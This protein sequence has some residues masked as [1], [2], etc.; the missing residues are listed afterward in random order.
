MR[1]IC[2]F[3]DLM[4]RFRS[5][6][7]VM[8]AGGSI[9]EWQNVRFLYSLVEHF[10]HHKRIYTFHEYL[11]DHKEPLGLPTSTKYRIISMSGDR[12]ARA[13]I[14][15]SLDQDIPLVQVF[16]TVNT[17]SKSRMER[18]F[19][20]Q[21]PSKEYVPEMKDCL[22]RLEGLKSG[23]IERRMCGTF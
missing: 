13:S 6:E 3:S 12:L 21:N 20:A 2:T 17:T 1:L 10:R 9:R 7:E 11:S 15:V 5:T 18:L 16:R 14:E 4:E 22:G 19:R 8:T 23:S